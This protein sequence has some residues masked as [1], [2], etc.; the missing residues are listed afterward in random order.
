MNHYDV[1]FRLL[2]S[3]AKLKSF[4]SGF[5]Q[6]GMIDSFLPFV[7]LGLTIP[8]DGLAGEGI[9]AYTQNV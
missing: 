7:Y 4:G 6:P 9:G 3:A 1:R 2:F 5:I 8:I